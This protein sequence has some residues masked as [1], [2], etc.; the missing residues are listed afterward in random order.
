MM[1]CVVILAS[2]QHHYSDK[3]F[4]LWGAWT[5]IFWWSTG[6]PNMFAS[7][8]AGFGAPLKSA[9]AKVGISH[10]G[11]HLWLSSQMVSWYRGMHMY[12]IYYIVDMYIYIYLELNVY[13]KGHMKKCSS[14]CDCFAGIR[15]QIDSQTLN[16]IRILQPNPKYNPNKVQRC[17]PKYAQ[18]KPNLNKTSH[19]NA[20]PS[21]MDTYIY[22]YTWISYVSL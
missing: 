14:L 8:L 20:L 7:Q 16:T 10:V 11:W 1:M 3:A 4:A 13:N 17:K 5:M 12:I 6:W 9:S 21:S 19:F 22:I 18:S 15:A 2:S